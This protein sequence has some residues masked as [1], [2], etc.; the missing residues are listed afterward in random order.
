MNKEERRSF[1][2]AFFLILEI[3]FEMG[4]TALIFS[5]I[6]LLALRRKR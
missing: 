1:A 6:I 4:L 5:G 2:A 3:L